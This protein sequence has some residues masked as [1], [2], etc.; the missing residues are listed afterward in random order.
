MWNLRTLRSKA[1]RSPTLL[2]AAVVFLSG[3]PPTCAPQDAPA[4][5]PAAPAPGGGGVAP[6]PPSPPPAGVQFFEDFSSDQRGRFDWRLQTTNEPPQ[7]SFMGEHDMACN[8]PT[9]YRT[10]HQPSLQWGQ[11]HSNVDV[12]ASELVWWCAP[13]NDPAKGHMMTGL[14]TGSVATLSFSPKQTFTNVSKVCWD[15]NMSNLGEGKWVNVFVVPAAHVAANGGDL[16]YAAGSGEEST[17][18]VAV[19]LKLPAGALDFTWLRGTVIA[20]RHF[21][22]SSFQRSLYE[23]KSSMP[24]GMTTDPAPRFTICLDDAANQIVVERPDGATDTY[25]YDVQIP[26]GEVRVIFQDASY[27][28]TKHAGSDHALTWHWDNITIQ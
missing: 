21:G 4:P 12:S 19:P 22:G 2:V 27:N 23:W 5:A 8:A 3:C 24:G 13:G 1:L 17:N 15:Q 10:V 9:T 7:G 25:G 18:A 11:Q 28:P 14:D 26:Q 20:Y 16:A 6:A